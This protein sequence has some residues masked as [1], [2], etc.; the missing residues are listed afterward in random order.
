MFA[1]QII[2][3]FV[4]LRCAVTIND[5]FRCLIFTVTKNMALQ[6]ITSVQ[7]MH[8]YASGMRADGKTI[9]FVPTMGYLHD[10]HAAL[11]RH[12]CLKADVTIVSV[13]VNP[14]QFGPNEDFLRYPR[15]FERDCHIAE[16]AGATVMYAPS[17]EEMY[18]NGYSSMVLAGKEAQVFDGIARPGHFNG[19]VTVVTKLFNAVKPHIA[20]FGQKDYQQTLVV[21][22]LVKDLNFDI[23]II[24]A[25]TERE[26][27]GLARSSRNVYLSEH[28]RENASSIFKALTAAAHARQQGEKNAHILQAIMQNILM[29]IPHVH[30]EY[31]QAAHADTLAEI[32]DF[33]EKDSIVFLIAIRL[34]TTRLID[35]LVWHP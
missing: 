4:T 13:F 27:N 8:N 14:T 33:E 34:G 12:S 19:V 7:E 32:I 11:I 23:Q 2:E 29:T 3:T 24:I 16:E 30:I 22:R 5:Y 35:N 1:R 18:P 31:A 28:D 20:V 17:V 9:G 15:D 6:I 25:P 26:A 10:G 21:K